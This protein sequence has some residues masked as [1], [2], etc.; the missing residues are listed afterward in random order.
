MLNEGYAFV[1][2]L[3]LRYERNTNGSFGASP[4]SVK[5]VENMIEQRKSGKR[6]HKLFTRQELASDMRWKDGLLFP[7]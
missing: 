6:E 4:A 3:K 1:E 2:T 5:L 7:A